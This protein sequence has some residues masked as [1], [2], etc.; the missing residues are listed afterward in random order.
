MAYPYHEDVKNPTKW[1]QELVAVVQGYPQGIEKTVFKIQ[2]FDWKSEKP[3]KSE[4]LEEWL[5][6]L[7][8]A[9]ARHVA[10]Y[11]DDYVLDHPKKDVIR[12]MISAED[13]PFERDWK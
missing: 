8:A 11:P 4:K 6:T 5:E 7:V 1:F 9:G 3:I 2:T 13:F 10:Y 12:T